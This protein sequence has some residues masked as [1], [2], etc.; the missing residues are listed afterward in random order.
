MNVKQKK[1]MNKT[2]KYLR[3]LSIVVTGIAITVG[4]GLWVNNNT[5]KKDQKQYFN[6]MIL[7]LK[8]NAENFDNYVKMMQKSVRYSNYLRSQNIETLN[9]D[10]IQYYAFT[11]SEGFGWGNLDP[12]IL[13]NEDAFEMFKSSGSMRQIDD[14]ELLLSIWKV[15][16]Q[17]KNTQKSIDDNMVYKKEVILDELKRI[18]N[19]EQIVARA[20][21]FYIN[22]VP[23][24]MVRECEGV[25]E[26]IRET[27][28]KLENSEIVK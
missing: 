7:E 11:T 10:S 19:G 13:Y 14:K 26:F 12:V 16:H 17:M 24:I 22:N 4:I 21:W 18:D 27:V 8:E 23:L 2:V 9:Q 5:I 20:L 3:E 28:S 25:T 15:Y 6:A 1:I